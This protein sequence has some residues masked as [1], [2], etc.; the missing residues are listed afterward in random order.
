MCLGCDDTSESRRD[1]LSTSLQL[2][3]ASA[4]GGA[5]SAANA[6]TA[7]VRDIEAKG[8]TV[9]NGG[10]LIPAYTASPVGANNRTTVVILHGNIGLPNDLRETARYIARAGYV[11]LV[12]DCFSRGSPPG[13]AGLDLL[14][15]EAY[16]QQVQTDVR[17][18]I[19]AING[20]ANAN[21]VVLMG[22]GGGGYTAL[23]MALADPLLISGVI[24]FYTAIESKQKSGVDPRP[25][26]VTLLARLNVPTQ[27]HIGTMDPY[28]SR[29]Q[30]NWL[31]R[32]VAVSPDRR[33]LF[34]YGGAGY[35][36][37]QESETG[38]DKGYHMLAQKRWQEF[39]TT[40]FD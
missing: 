21:P 4:L 31:G 6:A 2:A 14:L 40:R 20:T 15:G 11:A 39:L 19:A 17:A 36:F 18:G 27:F 34:T 35:G 32:F 29:E 3:V 16:N 30:L 38:F 13:T 10:T 33:Q 23:R 22:F 5:S 9:D 1:F 8:M 24:T 37:Y 7:A 28:I 26:L 12:L 25:D